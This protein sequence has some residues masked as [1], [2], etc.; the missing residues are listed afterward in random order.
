MG[1]GVHLLR[2]DGGPGVDPDCQDGGGGGRGGSR[3][4]QGGGGVSF[5]WALYQ[6][7]KQIVIEGN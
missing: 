6:R 2:W 4:L 5:E 7:W 1:G 3:L